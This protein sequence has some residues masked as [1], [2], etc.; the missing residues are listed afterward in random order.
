MSFK[1]WSGKYYSNVETTKQNRTLAGYVPA[2]VLAGFNNGQLPGLVYPEIYVPKNGSLS[3]DFAMLDG[4]LN[5]NKQSPLLTLKG[6]KVY[7]L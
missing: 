5:P 7:A 1:D 4:T 6:Q 2:A 3:F